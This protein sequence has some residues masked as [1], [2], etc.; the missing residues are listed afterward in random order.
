M[1]N[2][3]TQILGQ[4]NANRKVKAI[5]ELAIERGNTG[6]LVKRIDENRELLELLHERV[7]EFVTSHP[8]LVGWIRANDHFFTQL[9]GILETHQAMRMP[10]DYPRPW[11]GF[12]MIQQTNQ[13]DHKF[14]APVAE[15]I[16]SEDKPQRT[17][18]NNLD[19]EGNE[20]LKSLVEAMQGTGLFEVFHVSKGHALEA[21]Q[22]PWSYTR[23][24]SISFWAT[25]KDAR[26][27]LNALGEVVPD[28]GRCKSRLQSGRV[29]HVDARFTYEHHEFETIC[30][31]ASH[32][33]DSAAENL[34]KSIRFFGLNRS[35]VDGDFD[36]MRKL[37]QQRF[38]KLD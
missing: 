6:G 13:P 22:N 30:R 7:P 26:S 8:W 16:M 23:A 17:H 4:S 18:A 34:S 31:L 1:K 9:E 2:F 20:H 29:W 36:S 12:D 3:L 25:A 38:P 24:P 35:G 15:Q 32:E 10:K 19:F 14:V 11:P 27:L 28:L 21:K 33:F 5:E 37:I